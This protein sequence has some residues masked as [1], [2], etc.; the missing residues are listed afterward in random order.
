MNY[1]ERMIDSS[2]I[3]MPKRNHVIAF[4][5]I[6][7]LDCPIVAHRYYPCDCCQLPEVVIVCAMY[8]FPDTIIR[9]LFND[10]SALS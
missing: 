1:V 7:T 5:S 2:R 10:R 3:A 8:P 4:T 6:Q 9:E